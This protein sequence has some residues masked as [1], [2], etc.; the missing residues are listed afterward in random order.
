M[1]IGPHGLHAGVR[2]GGLG[3]D[4]LV[5]SPGSTQHAAT[6]TIGPNSLH[7]FVRQRCLGDNRLVVLLSSIHYTTS[8]DEYKVAGMQGVRLVVY[9]FRSQSLIENHDHFL[10]K[11]KRKARVINKPFEKIVINVLGETMIGFLPLKLGCSKA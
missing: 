1:T 4:R 2:Q 3:D 8:K 7:P 6:L 9:Q 11:S 10:I 5:V